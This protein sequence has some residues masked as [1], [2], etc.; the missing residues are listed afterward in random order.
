MIKLFN[1][2]SITFLNEKWDVIKGNVKIKH[3]PR[4]NELIF[5]PEYN[6][7]FRVINVIYN[8]TERQNIF[9]ILEDYTGDLS[10]LEKKIK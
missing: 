5:L 8:F 7:Y 2:D 4:N 3:I 6:R 9:V 10:L 1:R